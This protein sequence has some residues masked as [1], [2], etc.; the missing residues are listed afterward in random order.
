MSLQALSAGK[1]KGLP[2]QLF[3]PDYGGSFR[4]FALEVDRGT[5]PKISPARRKSYFNA[6]RLY[7][8]VIANDMYHQHYGLRAN[9]QVPGC[10]PVARMRSGFLS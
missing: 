3:A 6:I 9:L 4:I 2:D 1:A 7:E 10:S 5:E 8:H